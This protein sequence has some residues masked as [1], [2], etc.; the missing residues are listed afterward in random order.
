MKKSE[1]VRRYQ[2]PSIPEFKIDIKQTKEE[3]CILKYFFPS[4]FRKYERN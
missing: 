1:N 4:Y 2:C 3:K